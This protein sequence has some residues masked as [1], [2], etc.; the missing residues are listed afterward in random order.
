M[1]FD[2]EDGQDGWLALAPAPSRVTKSFT[3]ENPTGGDYFTIFTTPVGLLVSQIDSM[4]KGGTNC[5]WAL[6]YGTNPATGAGTAIITAGTVTSTLTSLTSTRTF[7]A[8]TIPAANAVSL[9]VSGVTGAVT[10][11]HVTVMF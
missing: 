7:D 3:L 4:I 1:A 6:Y 11:L 5:K 8:P 9:Y 10:E 2:G